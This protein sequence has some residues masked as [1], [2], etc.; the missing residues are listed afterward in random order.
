M[1]INLIVVL[2]AV[3]ALAIWYFF[4]RKT[5]AYSTKQDFLKD[6]IGALLAALC[7]LLYSLLTDQYP[8]FEKVIDSATFTGLITWFIYAI[9][10]GASLFN[11]VKAGSFAAYKRYSQLK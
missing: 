4:L 11:V 1:S 7:P 6:I 2:I 8:S 5:S 9:F 3:V 10:W